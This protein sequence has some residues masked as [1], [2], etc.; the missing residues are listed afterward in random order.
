MFIGYLIYV[1]IAAVMTVAYL[2]VQHIRCINLVEKHQK[3]W[4]EIKKGVIERGGDVEGAY[5]AY[6]DLLWK[7]RDTYIG[8]GFPRE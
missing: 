5:L 8:A 2:T 4:S 7:T 1:A 3:E 6:I